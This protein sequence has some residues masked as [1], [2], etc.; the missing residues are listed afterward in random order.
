MNSVIDVLIEKKSVPPVILLTGSKDSAHLSS[1][2]E[3]A[4]KLLGSK[5]ATKIEHGNHPDLHIYEIEGKN[6]MHS[7]AAMQQ[8][9]QEVAFK[10]FEAD[11]KIFIINQAERMLASSSNALLKTLEEPPPDCYLILV[12]HVP[13]QL[14]PTLLSRCRKI[15]LETSLVPSLS[16]FRENLLRMIEAAFKGHHDLLIEEICALEQTYFSDNSD[17]VKWR[18]DLHSLFEEILMI[19]RDLPQSK[20]MPSLEMVAEMIE[21]ASLGIEHHIKL[22]SALLHFFLMLF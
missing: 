19:F 21:R 8:L 1:A 7:M 15:V 18:A 13:D 9:L 6:G 2:K 14:P 16:P 12:S 5:H 3:L 22:R 20:E 17:V 4:K 10:P 11:F